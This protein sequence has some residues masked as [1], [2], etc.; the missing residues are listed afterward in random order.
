MFTIMEKIPKVKNKKQAM[1]CFVINWF[2]PGVGT[3]I[4]GIIDNDDDTVPNIVMGVLQ[5]LTAPILIG[6]I[7]A[8]WWGYMILKRNSGLNKF[9][10]DV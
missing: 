6:W 4:A 7:W 10:P 9:I 8:I 3:I 2:F 5:L 1:M